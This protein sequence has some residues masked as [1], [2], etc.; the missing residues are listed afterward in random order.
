MRKY[1]KLAKDI[2][3]NVGGKEN[4]NSLAHCVTRLR[5]KLKDESKANDDVL[6]NMDGVVTVM[7][8]GGQYQVVIGNHVPDVYT[9]VCDLA[10]LGGDV[11]GESD[12]PKGL[13]NKFIDLISGV[14][15]PILGVMCAAGMIKGFNALFIAFGLYTITDGTYMMLNSIGDSIFK[16]MPIILG[17]TAAKKFGAKPFL[18]LIIGA[19]LC[20]PDIQLSTLSSA[21]EPL[22]TVF[23]G[24]MFES[25]VY[26]TFLGLP[27]IAMDYTS[28]VVPVILIV[29]IASKL[30]KFF[31]KIIPD[32][33]KNFFVPMLVLLVSLPLGFIVIGPIATFGSNIVGNSFLWLFNLSPIVCGILLGLLWQCLV[34]FGLHWGLIPIAMVNMMTTG[35]DPILAGMFG[36]SFAQTAVVGA[37]Y[38]KLKDKKTKELC[39]PAFVSG[40]CG[41]TEPSIYGITLPR[42]KPFVFSCIGGAAGGAVMGL[43]EVQSYTMGGFGI[44]GVANYINTSTGDS[45]GAITSLICIVVSMVVGFLLTFFFWKDDTVV[46]DTKANNKQNNDKKAQREV[47][48]S[49]IKGDAKPLEQIED[50]AFSSGVL[51]KGVAITP[52]EGKVVAPFNGTVMTLFPTK[53]AIGIVSENGCELL[54]HIGLNTVQL[55]GKYFE[56]FVSQGDKIKKG[57]T[58]ITFDIENILKEGY[59]LDTPVVVTNYLDY[60]DVVEKTNKSISSNQELITVL[61]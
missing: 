34:I 48:Y 6:K 30:E 14:F 51:G 15:Q 40:I 45:S 43:M 1:E 16:F 42:K 22:Y 58:L 32:V 25:P 20:Y 56:T 9:V 19:A 61:A 57:Q 2:I 60:I 47:I 39:I 44:F 55:D 29:F 46:E 52:K 27:V 18:G 36:T 38:F 11:Q 13:L 33:V 24:T 59:S 12:S 50:A 41:I 3:A 54:I 5:F 7:K 4:I 31:G 37:M 8:S 53:H 35:S 28:T 17:Y 23:S 10:G 26:M 49:P 21:G